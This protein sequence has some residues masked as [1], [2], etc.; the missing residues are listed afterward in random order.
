V[1]HPYQVLG[2]SVPSLL[3]RKHLLEQIGRHL[4]KPSPDH[5]QV[6]GPSLYGKSVLLSQLA[7]NHRGGSSQYL[8]SAYAD[9]RHTPP[10]TDGEFRQQFGVIVK[11]ALTR[12]GSSLA[13]YI[14]LGDASA[15]ELLVLVFDE[16]DRER[17]RLLVVLD[18]FD[19]V[20]EGTGLTPNI[21]GQLRALAQRRSLRLVTGSRRP[22]RELCK[23]DES[24]TSDFWEIFYD[25][26]IAVGA[27]GESDWDDLI[28]PLI[29]AGVTVDGS[30]RKEIANWSGGVPILAI[31]LL[32]GLAESTSDGKICTKNEVDAIAGVMLEE[33]R[34]LLA[35]IWEDCD[36]DLRGDLAVLASKEADGIPLS[37]LSDRR[38]RTLEQR[39][40]GSSSGHRMRASCRLM[41]R[42][43]QQQ[44]P[45]VAD[46]K[47]LFGTREGFEANIRGLLEH[48]LAQVLDTTI[49][50]DLRSFVQSAVR[51]LE[52]K[53]E[54]A[55][56][57]VRSI[58]NR[59]LALIW[60]TELESG[61]RLPDSWV[62]EWKQGR[63]RLQWLD[64]SQRLPRGQGAQCHV[65]RLATGAEGI[66]PMARFATKPTA[67]LVDA[68][69]SVGDFAQHRE[70]YR[71]S[72]VSKGYA[73]AV[74]MSAIELA[75]SLARDLAR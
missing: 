4:M 38:Q 12:A 25:T 65:L 26:P 32:G 20:L 30:A 67:L 52:P 7:A 61:Q 34:Q 27:F 11:D 57:W 62:N 22:L 1:N 50:G 19:H 75:E 23:S 47:R 43:A 63:D 49:D 13:D 72:K 31:A 24:R 17:K 9:L 59:C 58:V 69:Q 3:G 41:A 5:V 15:H 64:G 2:V 71:E 55:L 10:T 35:E 14:D 6:V 68:L 36:V 66:R 74:V 29:A 28:E 8:T 54:L 45:A 16:L 53:P 44:A 60:D 37:E 21:W 48:R 73:A 70:D 42:F 39:G 33:R 40:L 18:G 56:K 51:D 46:L